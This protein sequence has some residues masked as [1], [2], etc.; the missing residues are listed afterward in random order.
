MTGRIV[1]LNQ[2]YHP[3]FLTGSH[4]YGT[5]TDGSDVDLVVVVDYDDTNLIGMLWN[6]ADSR[7]G[8]DASSLKFGKLNL[9]SVT[10]LEYDRWKKARDRCLAEAPV[11]RERAIEI[12]KEEKAG[13]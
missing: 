11:T 8:S 2:T 13:R 7:D 1:D 5:P 10:P 3:A 6:E 4:V 9:I 12:H